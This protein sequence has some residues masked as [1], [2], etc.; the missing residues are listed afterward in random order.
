MSLMKL[1]SPDEDK[2][3]NTK[4]GKKAADEWAKVYKE[5]LNLNYKVSNIEKVNLKRLLIEFGLTDL[6]KVI[7]Y[8]IN[9]YEN[10]S[11]IKGYPSINAM[12]GFRR[13]LFPEVL[14]KSEINFDFNTTKEEESNGRKE[15][16]QTSSKTSSKKRLW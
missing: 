12:M 7:N 2:S 3:Y 4:D 6:L 1:F 10:I 13:T 9:N 11:Y 5:K 15:S 16:D 8:Y 14:H